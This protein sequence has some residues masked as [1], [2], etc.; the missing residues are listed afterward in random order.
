MIRFF[1]SLERRI[2][3]R[4]QELSFGCYTTLWETYLKNSLDLKRRASFF[5]WA[6]CLPAVK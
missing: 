5:V 1:A 6:V 2:I 4:R 3:L